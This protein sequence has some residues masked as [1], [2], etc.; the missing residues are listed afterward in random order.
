MVLASDGLWDVLSKNEVMA[1]V[2]DGPEIDL[3]KTCYGEEKEERPY[4]GHTVDSVLK[5]CCEV[6]GKRVEEV[7][8]MERGMRRNYHDDITIAVINLER[9][10]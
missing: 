6:T 10:L 5:R 9:Q 1:S 8:K 3:N 2:M 7:R 4:M